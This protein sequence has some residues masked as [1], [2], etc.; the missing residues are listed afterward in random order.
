MN[1]EEQVQYLANVFYIVLAD[2]NTDKNEEKAF[3]RIAQAIGAGYF[4]RRNAQD[5]A[6]QDGFEVCPVGRLSD[7]FRNLED[8]LFI[9][10]CNQQVDAAEKKLIIDYATQIAVNQQQ[11]GQIKQEAKQRQEDFRQRTL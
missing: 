10:Y 5:L 11:F 6:K 8:M 7:R 4:E 3:E 9:S 1:K 2:G